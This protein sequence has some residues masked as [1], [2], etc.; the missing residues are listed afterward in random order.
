MVVPAAVSVTYVL[1]WRRTTEAG[2]FWG[3]L[4]GY[5][6]GGA[7]FAL[8]KWALWADL[9]APQG[10]SIPFRW[11]AALLT[12]GGEGLDPAY[13][14]TLVPLLMVPLVSLFTRTSPERE[15]EF[16]ARLAGKADACA[17]ASPL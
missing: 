14:T 10:A 4:T 9:Q 3:M 15:S 17:A 8:V 1:Y 11:L 16:R 2:A 7:W 12:Q 5:A 13:V 6:A